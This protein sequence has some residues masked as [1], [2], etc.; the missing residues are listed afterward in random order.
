MSETT[1]IPPAGLVLSGGGAKGAYQVGVLKALL[2]LG[3]N[4]DRVA[5]ASMGALNGAVLACAP[6]LPEGVQRLEALWT[7]LAAQSP[8]EANTPAYL[9][10]LAA[11]GLS[12]GI[13]LS[14]VF[15]RIPLLIK[16]LGPIAGPLGGAAI[17][18]W[19]DL[20]MISDGPL[21]ALMDEYLDTEG[22]MRGLPLYVSVY[23]SQG[24]IGDVLGCAVA[25][26][27][28]KDTPP[29][30]FVHVQSLPQEERR[31]ALL[32]S[33][34]IPLLYQARQLGDA[35]AY[36][37]G[38]QGGWQTAQ[39]NTPITPLIEAGCKQVIVTHLSDGSL[40]SRHDFPHITVLEIRPQ[41]PITPASSPLEAAR[42]ALGFDSANIA[43]LID[44]GYRDT[45]HCLG[46][47][48]Q[49]TRAR[50]IL[51]QSE[52]ALGDNLRQGRAADASLAD[53]MARLDLE[54]H[55][56]QP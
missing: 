25:E 49:A 37:D 44:Q 1:M 7:T 5:G 28:F 22:L 11:A 48:M 16:S 17:A 8:V 30:R 26:A 4:I 3:A 21:K 14:P 38:G 10:L 18:K 54:T 52:A 12:L 24:G 23:E 34:A 15:A 31:N 50:S 2:E 36:S 39:G 53:A 55:K 29:S 35:A 27:G 19:L 32:A 43:R 45:H 46:R 51:K 41:S 20:A 6:S 40:W 42:A 56:P 9:K 47:V 13:P 33:A